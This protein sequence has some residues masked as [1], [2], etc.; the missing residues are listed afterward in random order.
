MMRSRVL[1]LVILERA[2][3][4]RASWLTLELLKILCYHVVPGAGDLALGS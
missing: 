1:A 2:T 4:S 3:Y